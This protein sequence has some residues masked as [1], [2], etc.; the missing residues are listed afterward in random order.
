[1]DLEAWRDNLAIN[2]T[3]PFI[4]SKAVLAAMIEQRSGNIFN[5]SSGASVR[6]LAGYVAYGTAKAGLNTFSWQLAQ[7]VKEYGIAVNAWMPGLINTDMSG[8]RGDDVS[9]IV[10][11]VM[12]ILSQTAETFTGQVL[13]RKHFGELY[14]PKAS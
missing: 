10:P 5:I 7:E 13:E 1:M 6:Y 14:G 12:W 8:H 11:S 4:M 9:A 2:L 3:T